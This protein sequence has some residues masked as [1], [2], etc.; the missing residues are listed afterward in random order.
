MHDETSSNTKL[1]DA[2]EA[3]EC[4]SSIRDR[5]AN[6]VKLEIARLMDMAVWLSN[7]EENPQEKIAFERFEQKIKARQID[8]ADAAVMLAAVAEAARNDYLP[9]NDRYFNHPFGEEDAFSM[10]NRELLKFTRAFVDQLRAFRFFQSIHEIDQRKQVCD[11]CH[12]GRD[13]HPAADSWV[14]AVGCGHTLCAHKCAQQVGEECPVEGCK[15]P[16]EINYLINGTAIGQADLKFY[17]FGEKFRQITDLIKN[18]TDDDQVL[19]FYQLETFRTKIVQALERS[20]ISFIELMTQGF[21]STKLH[22]FQHGVGAKRA[23][24]LVLNI[25]DA[26]AA[27]R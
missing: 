10:I 1:R 26:S 21:Q 23:K 22:D 5:Q 6:R 25:G 20:G 17:E 9:G 18:G 8:D 14:V 24:C 16:L 15:A 3:L 4:N 7:Q 12:A 19:L 2:S 13:A 11:V 27:G